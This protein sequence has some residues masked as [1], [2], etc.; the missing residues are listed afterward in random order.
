MNNVVYLPAANRKCTD[1]NC[2][3]AVCE[4]VARRDPLL[5]FVPT[6]SCGT[7]GDMVEVDVAPLHAP[8]PHSSYVH[9]CDDCGGTD[10]LARAEVTLPEGMGTGYVMLCGRCLSAYDEGERKWAK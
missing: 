8:L 2:T 3:K 4:T 7:C 5:C 1:C 10:S 9:S 6:A